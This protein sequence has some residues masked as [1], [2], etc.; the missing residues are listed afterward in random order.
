MVALLETNYNTANNETYNTTQTAIKATWDS[1]THNASSTPTKT[2]NQYLPG[3]TLTIIKNRSRIKARGKDRWGRWN[4]LS[5]KGKSNRTITIINAYIPCNMNLLANRLSTYAMQLWHLQ[6]EVDIDVHPNK[7]AW[8]DLTVFTNELQEKGD[9][10]IL[11]VDANSD[12]D[13]S[14]SQIARYMDKCNLVDTIEKATDQRN[15]QNTHAQETARID[16]ILVSP[17]LKTALISAEI[18]PLLTITTADHKAIKATFEE[19]KLFKPQMNIPISENRILSS[20]SPSKLPIYLDKLQWHCKKHNICERLIQL[21]K[22]FQVLS[23]DVTPAQLIVTYEKIA[24]QLKRGQLSSEKKCRKIHRKFPW[25]PRLSTCGRRLHF[26]KELMRKKTSMQNTDD[27]IN[28]THK[29]RVLLEIPLSIN[30]IRGNKKKCR[31]EL[32]QA[33]KEAR[34]LRDDFLQERADMYALKH[35]MQS[36]AAIKQLLN[37][38]KHKETFKK[39]GFYFNPFRDGEV[40]FLMMDK[41]DPRT[42]IKDPVEIQNVLLN[43]NKK[44]FS[45]QISPL[46]HPPLDSQ[47]GNTGSGM[48]S[49][50]I[51]A[52]NVNKEELAPMVVNLLES[53]EIPANRRNLQISNEVSIDELKIIIGKTRERTA[54]SPSQ[55]HMGHYKAAALAPELLEIILLIINIPF[56]FG[57]VPKRWRNSVHLMLKKDPTHPHP[58]KMRIIQLLEADLNMYLKIIIGRRLSANA[59]KEKLLENDL[60]G[61]RKNHS[62]ID[63]VATQML[64]SQNALME[65]KNLITISLDASKCFDRISHPMAYLAL[66]HFGANKILSRTFTS[67]LNLMEHRVKTPHGISSN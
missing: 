35:D 58:S 37:I 54:S 63:A 40:N 62:A 64:I 23:D 36:E 24:T 16:V 61:G 67:L 28:N 33:Q 21:T 66:R 8:V 39:I 31:N 17:T 60:H 4:W 22:Q 56:K 42:I 5:L 12:C 7:Q 25:S 38:E 2:K 47:L 57:F 44:K 11:C 46:Q 27:L 15:R 1:A 18:L 14:N 29:Y 45:D 50:E 20:E 41:D 55:I 43:T 52:G 9:L 13:A 51:L 26:W 53:L 30:D 48:R 10:L 6:R 3:G 59:E 34:D 32:R 49:E 65:R 19:N